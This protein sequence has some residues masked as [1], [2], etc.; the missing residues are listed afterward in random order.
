MK[1]DQDALTNTS[2][3]IQSDEYGMRA[4]VNSTSGRAQLE[5]ECPT[6]IVQQVYAVWG[7]TTTVAEPEIPPAP[8]PQPSETD[9]L[10][11]QVA[12]LTLSG[13]QKDIQITQLGQQLVQMQLDLAALK[14]GTAS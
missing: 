1:I 7:D 12:A 8:E 13:A 9:S 2:V 6:E 4:Y 14:E 11:Q 5:A 3:S 10:G